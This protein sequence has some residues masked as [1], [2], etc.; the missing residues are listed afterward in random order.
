MSAIHNVRY[1]AFLSPENL[2]GES[3]EVQVFTSV[4]GGMAPRTLEEG[5]TVLSVT[6]L[7]DGDD[8][9][10]LMPVLYDVDGGSLHISA[11]QP[12]VGDLIVATCS[13]DDVQHQAGSIAVV[14]ENGTIIPAQYGLIFGFGAIAVASQAVAAQARTPMADQS[15]VVL[16]DG[17][18]VAHISADTSAGD[19]EVVLP[20]ALTIREISVVNRNGGGVVDVQYEGETIAVVDS[21]AITHVT[22]KSFGGGWDVLD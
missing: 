2:S 11:F 8:L 3:L 6:V 1:G 4:E 16:V 13:Q 19:V 20:S 10:D 5:D 12:Q 22:L 21:T 17:D 14:A 18:G 15:P 7:P 9:P